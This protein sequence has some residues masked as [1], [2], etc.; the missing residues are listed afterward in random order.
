MRK[1]VR[2][3]K[4]LTAPSSG[5]CAVISDYFCLVASSKYKWE[6][7]NRKASIGK[8]WNTV[9]LIAG[10]DDSGKYAYVTVAF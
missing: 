1:R 2:E 5:S 4:D 8:P 9:S 10:E 6:D 7:V 3:S